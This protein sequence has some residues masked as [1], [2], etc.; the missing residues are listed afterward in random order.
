[1]GIILNIWC[2]QPVFFSICLDTPLHAIASSLAVA[3]C[4][5]AIAVTRAVGASPQ[6]HGRY[7]Y[8]AHAYPVTSL[9]LQPATTAVAGH[10][11]HQ[12]SD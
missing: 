9:Q 1:M 4:Y 7:S 10:I 3:G 8:A 5:C 12:L 11:P 6:V 2:K